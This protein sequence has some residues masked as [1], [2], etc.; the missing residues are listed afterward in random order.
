MEHFLHSEA[1]LYCQNRSME[2]VT[3][4]NEAKYLSVAQWASNWLKY[5][6]DIF[7]TNMSFWTGLIY[8]NRV[9]SPVLLAFSLVSCM[10]ESCM[11][12]VQDSVCTNLYNM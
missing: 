10:C 12:F 5:N 7:P 8:N 11:C 4:E 1:A 6:E 9:S 3:Y 2:L